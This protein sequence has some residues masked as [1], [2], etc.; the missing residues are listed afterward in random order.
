[1]SALSLARLSIGPRLWFGFA[2]VLL[3]VLIV[4]LFVIRQM[5]ASTDAVEAYHTV[6]ENISTGQQ[7]A[8]RFNELRRQAILFVAAEKADATALRNASSEVGHRLAT[9]QTRLASQGRADLEEVV[10]RFA[11]YSS[12]LGVLETARAARDASVEKGMEPA[13]LAAR[14]ALIALRDA[15]EGRQDFAVTIQAAKAESG[16]Q[17]AQLEALR[18]LRAA[19]AESAD[20]ASALIQDARRQ[21]ADLAT[22]LP[23]ALADR[24]QAAQTAV[25]TYAVAFL[26]ARRAMETM[27]EL[28]SVTNRRHA[29]ALQSALDSLGS[30]EAAAG[31]AAEAHAGAALDAAET[32]L[33]FGV[34]IALLFGMGF[35]FVIARSVSH[36]IRALTTVTTR[37]SAGDLAVHVPGTERGDETGALARAVAV[38]QEGLRAAEA[39]RD[40]AAAARMAAEAE[41]AASLRAM[42]DRVE[43]E[44]GAA[45]DAV[46]RQMEAMAAD[47]TAMAVSAESVAADS[48][49]VSDAA[50]EAQRNINTVAAATEQ[51]GASIREITQQINGA[52]QAT[53][54][55]A[56][57]GADGRERIAVLSQEVER[58]GGVARVIA[59]IAGQTNLLALNATIEAARA[60]EAGKGFAVVASEVKQLAA[61]TAKAT[62]EIARQVQEVTTATEGAVA[63]VRDMADAVAQ[64]DQAAA[65]IAAAMEEQSAATQEI[66][67]AVAETSAAA[68]Q[69]AESIGA[70]SGEA[71]ENGARAAHMRSGADSARKAVAELRRTIIRVLREAAPE[72]QRRLQ[73]RVPVDIPVRLGGTAEAGPWRLYDLSAGGCS[74]REDSPKLAVGTVVTISGDGPLS[75][76]SIAARVAASPP[77]EPRLRLRFEAKDPATIARLEAAIERYV[78]AHPRAA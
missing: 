31:A 16:L 71:T 6:T 53:G 4:G 9:L 23:P 42:A 61:Q 63:I 34:G 78:A 24:S 1:L 29:E 33:L 67:R 2:M 14:Q 11:V 32:T 15:A 60:G 76:L 43:S 44:G 5:N 8:T 69:V 64:V 75:G 62:E 51:L 50:G 21:I 54:L 41:R 77:Q 30:V 57:R 22:G 65:A 17:V 18:F 70:V 58:I 12:N 19:S 20:R 48:T 74:L 10:R 47:A 37:L 35:A 7:L 66:A 27:R 56:Q 72:V 52:T 59:D 45:V 3:P 73:L 25:E 40:A 39:A 55:A 46:A 26:E 28:V 36:P 38:F 13:G 68:N 49:S